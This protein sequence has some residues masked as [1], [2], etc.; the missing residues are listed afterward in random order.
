MT[1][2]VDSKPAGGDSTLS[3]EKLNDLL[4]QLSLKQPAVPAPSAPPA[5]APSGAP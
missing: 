3:K 1:R 2:Q 4:K 5:G